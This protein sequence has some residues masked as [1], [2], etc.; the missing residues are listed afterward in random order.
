MDRNTQNEI[1]KM[2]SLIES[3]AEQHFAS[4]LSGAPHIIAV[5]R[6]DETLEHSHLV[7]E[8]VRIGLSQDFPYLLVSLKLD[9]DNYL[10]QFERR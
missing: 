4:D 2:I 1:L 3:D 7:G 5:P 6:G 10:F 8:G 9:E